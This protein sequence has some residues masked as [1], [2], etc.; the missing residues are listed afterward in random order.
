MLS[1][2]IGIVIIGLIVGLLGRLIVPGRDPIGIIATILLGIA[3]SFIGGFVGRALFH[4]TGTHFILSV[5]CAALLVLVMRRVGYGGRRAG[6]G[7]RA[8]W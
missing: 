1:L 8:Y 7:R 3:G 5:I 6:F 4:S 2:I